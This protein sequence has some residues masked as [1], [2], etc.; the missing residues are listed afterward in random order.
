MQTEIYS[1]K[2]TGVCNLLCNSIKKKGKLMD[3]EK[4]K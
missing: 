3:G 2:Y 1:E 4:D